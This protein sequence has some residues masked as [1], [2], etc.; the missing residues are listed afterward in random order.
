ML[1]VFW[2]DLRQSGTNRVY[3]RYDAA[4][5]RYIVQWSRMRNDNN[6]INNC[7]VILYDP[8]VHPTLTGDGLIVFQ[9]QAVNNNDYDRAYCTVGIQSPDG[10]DGITW[11]YYNDYAPTLARAAG[12]PRHRLPAD[13]APAGRPPAPSRRNCWR[14]RW[15]RANRRR[16]R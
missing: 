10:D 4:G 13:P 14:S 1:A 12:R 3:R 6:G 15:R 11:T 2:D 8:A 16:A 7:E 5:G 9:Y